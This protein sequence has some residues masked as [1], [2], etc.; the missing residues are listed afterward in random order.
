MDLLF[1]PVKDNSFFLHG[2]G[3][4]ALVDRRSF[5][6]ATLGMAAVIDAAVVTGQ[7]QV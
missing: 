5:L 7:L 3:N 6:Q 4:Y 1:T 2:S